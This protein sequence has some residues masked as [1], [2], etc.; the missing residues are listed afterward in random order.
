M[1]LSERCVLGENV[2]EKNGSLLAWKG[3]LLMWCWSRQMYVHCMVHA[4]LSNTVVYE[5]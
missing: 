5:G 1:S 4:N 3:M 2:C